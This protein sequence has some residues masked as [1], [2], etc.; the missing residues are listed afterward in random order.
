MFKISQDRFRWILILY[1]RIQKVEELTGVCV[2]NTNMLRTPVSLGFL[3]NDLLYNRR[4]IFIGGRLLTKEFL[5]DDGN[6]FVVL[7]TDL[8][9]VFRNECPDNEPKSSHSCTFKYLRTR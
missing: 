8:R 3:D 1:H 7:R 5:R 9:V 6:I 2:F 4:S